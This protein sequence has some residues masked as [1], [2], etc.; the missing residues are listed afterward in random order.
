MNA[1]SGSAPADE[2]RM[3]RAEMEGRA[4]EVAELLKTLSHPARL[5]LA[6]TLAE[7][8][9]SV[10]ELEETLGIRQPT[11]SQQLGVL[12][13]AGV[14]E[15]RREAKQI[16]YRLTEARAAQLIEALYGIFCAPEVRS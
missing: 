11:L 2:N 14:V 12:R 10:G 6:C 16:F 4:T 1:I 5:M 13:E 9:Y 15:T 7:R 8:E 3:T